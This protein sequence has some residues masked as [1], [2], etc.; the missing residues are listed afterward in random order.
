MVS[1]ST[2]NMT[3]KVMSVKGPIDPESLGVTIMHEHLFMAG[4]FEGKPPDRFVPATESA[5]W[6][7]KV[8]LENVHHHHKREGAIGDGKI[9]VSNIE[10]V[11]R[12]RTGEKDS[13]AI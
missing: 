1:K 10:E 7:E 4:V 5:L 11:T 3:G 8:T 6:Y 9:F 13:E 2:A 12:I